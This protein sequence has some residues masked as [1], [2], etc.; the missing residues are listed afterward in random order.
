MAIIPKSKTVQL[1]VEPEFFDRLSARSDLT[2]TSVSGLIRKVMLAWLQHQEDRE[3]KQKSDDEFAAVLA[4]RSA[5]ATAAVG[6]R[7]KKKG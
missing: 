5:A 4:S 7:H 2:N 1:R 3:A 6:P